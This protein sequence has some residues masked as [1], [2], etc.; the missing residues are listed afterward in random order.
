[1]ADVL[2]SYRTH[3]LGQGRGSAVPETVGGQTRI[4]RGKGALLGLRSL[5]VKMGN[6]IVNARHTIVNHNLV[7]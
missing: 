6:R 7:G 2:W 1:M 5:Y 3:T 4:M